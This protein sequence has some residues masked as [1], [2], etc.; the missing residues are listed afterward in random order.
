MAA[1]PEFTWQEVARQLNN[2]R[3]NHKLHNVMDSEDINQIR[4]RGVFEKR[5][6]R[7]LK[8][9]NKRTS[10]QDVSESKVN[11]SAI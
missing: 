5:K 2:P 8:R 9:M 4:I 3:E 1:K 11:Y 6:E 7:L 10:L